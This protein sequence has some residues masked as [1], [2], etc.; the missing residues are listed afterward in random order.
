MRIL[1][2]DIERYILNVC[3]KIKKNVIIHDNIITNFDFFFFRYEALKTG[4]ISFFPISPWS[5]NLC[6]VKFFDFVVLIMV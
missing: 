6:F 2:D 4:S 5:F 3:F 1:Q